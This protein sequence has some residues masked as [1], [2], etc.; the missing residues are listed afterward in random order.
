[1]PQTQADTPATNTLQPVPER[2]VVLT[3]DDGVKSQYTFVAPLLQHYGFGATF[4]IT[5]GLRFLEDK[6]RYLTWA[7]VRAL[8]DLGFE[9]GNHTRQHKNVATQTPDELSADLLHID[10]RCAEHGIPRPTTFCYPGYHTSPAAVQVIADHGFH[11]ARAGAMPEYPNHRE[12]GR[13]PAY[14]PTRHHPLLVPT[15]GAAGPTWGFADLV[16]AVEQATAGRIAVL[17]FHGVPD[18]DH[19]W[20]HTEPDRFAAYLRY[21]HESGCTVI[22]MRDL[23][24]Y[25]DSGKATKL[26][27]HFG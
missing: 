19:P 5:E 26:S 1:M 12:G 27:P 14:D 20:V 16:W 22:A 24:Q 17:T 6:S 11:F 23:A 21:L 13:G 25:V 9:I 2:L 7:E 3:F 15:T 8:H 10:Q 4:Y 18:L